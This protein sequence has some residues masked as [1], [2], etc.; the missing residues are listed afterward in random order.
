MVYA[1]QIIIIVAL[2]KYESQDKDARLANGHD[3][4]VCF[5]LDVSDWNKIKVSNIARG[6]LR[7][8]NDLVE[9]RRVNRRQTVT[10]QQSTNTSDVL[11]VPAEAD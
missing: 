7:A 11:E 3:C 6:H 1:Y 10:S 4:N 5:L 2:G 9:T 8:N